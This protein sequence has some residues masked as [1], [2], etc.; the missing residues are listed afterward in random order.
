MY[1]DIRDWG[2]QYLDVVNH[3][4]EPISYGKT[5]RCNTNDYI[6]NVRTHFV[7]FKGVGFDDTALNGIKIYGAKL[8][9]NESDY[10]RN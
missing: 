8:S 1:C 10:R 7:T 3:F 4:R 2:Q 5:V 9:N 6:W